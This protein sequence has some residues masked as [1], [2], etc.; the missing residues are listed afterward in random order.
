MAHTSLLQRIDKSS[1]GWGGVGEE[2]AKEGEGVELFRDNCRP[3]N[4]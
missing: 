3:Q 2:R 4:S 1:G